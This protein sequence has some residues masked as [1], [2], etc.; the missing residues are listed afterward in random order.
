MDIT[1][2]GTACIAVNQGIMYALVQGS[3]SGAYGG[4]LLVLIKSE[5]PTITGQNNAWSAISTSSIPVG[6]FGA[7]DVVSMSNVS[8]NVDKNGVFTYRNMEGTVGYRYIPTAPQKPKTRTCSADGNGLGEWTRIVLVNP[9]EFQKSI[10]LIIQP[11]IKSPDSNS[12][13]YSEEDEMAIYNLGWSDQLPSAIRYARIDKNAS[14]T[15]ITSSDI[16][17]ALL[18]SV[19]FHSNIRTSLYKS[20]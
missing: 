7:E 17:Q 8:C 19:C 15:K 5:Y 3:Q 18:V 2:S 9:V 20:Q 6:F 4:A 1:L 16:S 12:G 11:E 10:P 14:I 13:G